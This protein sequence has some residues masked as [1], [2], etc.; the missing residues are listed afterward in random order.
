MGNKSARVHPN[1]PILTTEHFL[2]AEAEADAHSRYTDSFCVDIF[3]IGLIDHD[4]NIQSKIWTADEMK[5]RID[6]EE[7]KK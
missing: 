1:H 5:N 4:S 6:D 2:Y 7:W 3:G